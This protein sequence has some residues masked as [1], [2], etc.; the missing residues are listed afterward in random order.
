MFK[1]C[2]NEAV[3]RRSKLWMAV[4]AIVP[5]AGGLFSAGTAQASPQSYVYYQATNSY[6][7]APDDDNGAYSAVIGFLVSNGQLT[8]TVHNTSNPVYD[9]SQTVGAIHFQINGYTLGSNAPN[10]QDTALNT[11]TVASNGSGTYTTDTTTS[12]AAWEVLTG[13]GT[14]TPAPGPHPIGPTGP[15][16]TGSELTLEA[17]P[18]TGANSGVGQ[19]GPIGEF[20]IGNTNSNGLYSSA[21][22]GTLGGHGTGNDNSGSSILGQTLLANNQSFTINLPGLT[23]A[24]SIDTSS[25]T[26]DFGNDPSDAGIKASLDSTY[27]TP[28]PAALALMG[29]ATL[30]LLIRR[31]RPA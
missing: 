9:V 1:S 13:S 10:L 21:L 29:V 28:E 11:I 25:I 16:A 14:T 5:M 24:D 22:S 4:A 6:S 23:T 27:V 18:A 12:T 8:V 19:N 2:R 31:R 20:V 15:I 7:T 17:I 3:S 30:G 26:V